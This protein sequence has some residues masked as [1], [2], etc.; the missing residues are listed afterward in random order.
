[1]DELVRH[2]LR[3]LSFDGDLGCDVSRLRDFITEFYAR[4]GAGGTQKQNVDDAYC[5]FVW[6][7]IVQQPGVRI[8]TVPPG[9]HA[10]VYI[11]PQASA[12]RKAKAKATGEQAAE[13]VASASALELIEDATIRS[14]E[15]LRNEYGDRLR[16]AADPETTFAALTGSH[17]RP[18]K[19]TGMIYTGLQIVTRGREQGV[20]VLDLGKKSGYDQKT[21]FYVIKQLVELDLV[22]KLRRPGI[23]TNLCVH[24]YFY[25]RSPIW[26]QVAQEEKKAVSAEQAQDEDAV[27]EEDD[28]QDETKPLAPVH[29]DPIDSRHLSSMPLLK[30]RLTKLLKNCPHYM[31]TSSNIMLKIGFVK[32][33]RTDRRFFRSRLRELMEQGVIE[34]VHVPHADRKKHPDRKVPCIRLINEDA[35]AQTQGEVVPIADDDFEG[36]SAGETGLKVNVSL[37]RQMIDLLAESGEK[38]MTL[39]EISAALGDF[40]KRTVDLLLNR[41]EK[42]PP[43]AHLADLGV[44]QLAETHGRERRYKYYT[45]AHYR[46][47]AEREGFEDNVY[48]AVDLAGVGGFLPVEADAFYEGEADLVA[49]IGRLTVT[50]RDTPASTKGKQKKRVNPILPDGSVKKGRPRKSA[51]A[52]GTPASTKK[53]KK[54]KR[55]EDE[56]GGQDGVATVDDGTEEP[57]PKKKRGRPPKK[58]AAATPSAAGVA[59]SA[60]ATPSVAKKRGRPPKQIANSDEQGGASASASGGP[61]SQPPAPKRRGRPPKKSLLPAEEDVF[62]TASAMAGPEA[63]PSTVPVADLPEVL[64]SA[65]AGPSSPLSPMHASPPRESSPTPAGRPTND[66]RVTGPTSAPEAHSV[67]AEESLSLAGTGAAPEATSESS[68]MAVRRS[69]RTPKV[70]KR[71]DS[72]S[73]ARNT[74]PPPRG[75]S[76][77]GSAPQ[78]INVEDAQGDTS[79]AAS[80]PAVVDDQQPSIVDGVSAVK[81][82]V[83]GPQDHLPSIAEFQSTEASASQDMSVDVVPSTDQVSFL[84]SH[85]HSLIAMTPEPEVPGDG[86]SISQGPSKK[87][88]LPETASSQPQ[89]KRTKSG[90]TDGSRFRSKANISQSR[91]ENEILRLLA[92][93]GNIMNTSCKE[94]YEAH[95][96][97]VE[98]IT[99][100]GEVASTRP[101]TKIDKR[102]LEATLT[103]LESKGKVKIVSTSVPNP[104]GSTRQVRVVYLPETTAEA[105]TIFLSDLS[106]AVQPIYMP[107]LKTLDEPVAYGG[108]RIKSQAKPHP[109]VALNHDESQEQRE[110]NASE[111]FLRDDQTIRDALLAEKNTVA[112]L[113]GYIVGKAARA[114]ALHM[115]TVG[116]FENGSQSTQVVS[117]TSRIMNLSYYYTDI[118]IS[119]Y[120]SLVTVTQPIEELGKLL[121]TPEGQATPVRDLH[122]G[123]YN[124]LTPTHT[125]SRARILVLLDMLRVLGL[126]TPLVPSDSPE[127]IITCTPASDHPAAYDIAPPGP[128]TPSTAPIYWRF[129]DIA[130]IRLWA[131]PQGLSVFWKVAAVSSSEEAMAFWGDSEKI[132]LDTAFAEGIL[133]SGPPPAEEVPEEVKAV[134]KTLR[135]SISWSA[136][137]SLSWYQTEYLRKYIDPATGDTPLEKPDGGAADLNKLSWIISAHKDVIAGH[138]AKARKKHL[139]DLKKVQTR[140][141]K[142]K[143]KAGDDAGA[144]LARRAAEAKE[145]RERDW[146]EMLQRV[147][148]GELRTAAAQRIQRVKTKFMQ[149]A[150]KPSEK[151][152]GK[153]RDAIREADLVAEKLLPASHTSGLPPMPVAKPVLPAPVVTATQEK[154]VDELIAAQG[155]RAQQEARVKKTKKGKEKDTGEPSGQTPRRHRFLWNRDYDELA[156][157]ASAIIK[158][159]CRDGTRLDWGALEQVFPAVPRNS[160]RQRLVHLRE[161]PGTDT[162]LARLEEK[163]RELWLQHRGTDVLPDDDP[164]SAGNFDLAAHVKFLRKH[165]DKNAIRVGFVEVQATQSTV[166]PASVEDLEA[167]YDVVEK[168]PTAPPWD[169]MWSVI[170]EEG[171]EKQFAQHA[172]TADVG[173]MPPTAPYESEWIQIADAAVKMTLG[174]PNETYDPDVASQ[175]L[176][177]VGQESVRVAT[178]ELLNRGVLAKTVR[179]PAKSKPGRTLKISD[180]NQNALGG[181]LPREVFQDASALEELVEQQEDTSQCQDWSLL[182]SDGDTAFLIEL[183]SENK[184]RFDVDTA[185]PRSMRAI[186]DWNSKKADDDDIETDIR[187]RYLDIAGPPAPELPE[188]EVAAEA[189]NT[190]V[191]MLLDVPC[192]SEHGKTADGDPAYCRRATEDLVDCQACLSQAEASL[193]THE[194]NE[195]EK[196]AAE[197]LLAVLR[198]AG[199]AGITKRQLLVQLDAFP[200]AAVKSAIQRATDAPVPL[201]HWT[202]Y[203]AV[204][205]VSAAYIRPWTVVVPA[206]EN[207]EPDADPRTKRMIFPRRWLDIYG[208]KLHEVWEAAL[209]AAVALVLL[210]PGISQAE[211]RWRLRAAYDRQEVGE[212]LRA[213]QEEGCIVRRRMGPHEWAVEVGP[214][215]DAEERATFWFLASG[216]GRRWYQV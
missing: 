46:A 11:A 112:Q 97:L 169:F 206:P 78:G 90:Q 60:S 172:F 65:Q 188:P 154:D 76:S 118:S 21:C 6:S 17:I 12:I 115:L 110:A 25:E 31:H 124:A 58:A 168:V 133:G 35:E 102:T 194:L 182:A 99:K 207:P 171:R 81:A 66:A 68:S 200:A 198:D 63:G 164:T 149:G 39:N 136:T 208:R 203:A 48:G 54:R 189:A 84:D 40:D 148:P 82:S 108:A 8:G 132:S 16:I 156:R 126:V 192:E 180:N 216:N 128:Y 3:E 138:F 62:G 69:A 19:L 121:E 105:L 52:D 178:T 53:G 85:G 130:P 36:P 187:V 129:N 204:A 209:R 195:H 34:K 14:L 147:H 193:L 9:T 24:K 123:L 30:S 162:Y 72:L 74:R 18:S 159:R 71:G 122:E 160:V 134:A 100:A 96:A 212:V 94:F 166:L 174:N 202:G 184:V 42:D 181:Q 98:T 142:G 75:Q 27:S 152:E 179:D 170:A 103:A 167:A 51:A 43:P 22:V 106:E 86:M 77:A 215:D 190:D 196:V 117:P 107:I 137:Y 199:A 87:R 146:E 153:I 13:E 155:H 113:Y 143:Q 104:T 83:M 7:V 210:R 93:A 44:A 114:R 163:W 120:C 161:V 50:K 131:L 64:P 29:F 45:V 165:I 28:D 145:Q 59:E 47:I 213:L 101:G 49:H 88:E 92:E 1:M 111:L 201:A 55:E 4:P 140:V 109:S 150:G 5:A 10:E 211:I 191:Q 61:S 141:A 144:V 125:K 151:W 70:R 177:S 2:C 33:S 173:D 23:S 89:S 116:I 32:P 37:H 38:G 80:M 41:L 20:S 15:D 135:R 175:L 157:D 183:A 95:A 127:P 91:R 214:A 56:D 158:A 26:Q 186:I 73:P 57:P 205:L 79:A 185:H 139:R 119:G 176:K 67:P 197:K